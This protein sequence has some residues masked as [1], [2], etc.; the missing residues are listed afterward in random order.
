MIR[1]APHRYQLHV[2]PEFASGLAQVRADA[3]TVE[4]PRLA[5]YSQQRRRRRRTVLVKPGDYMLPISSM[6]W[7]EQAIINIGFVMRDVSS[8]KTFADS[9]NLR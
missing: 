8:A 5:R 7:A 6:S 2:L 4:Q 1:I 3:A 9:R